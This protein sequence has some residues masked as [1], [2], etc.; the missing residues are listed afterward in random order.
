[1]VGMAWVMVMWGVAVLEVAGCS[2][3]VVV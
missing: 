1:M 2:W 3:L